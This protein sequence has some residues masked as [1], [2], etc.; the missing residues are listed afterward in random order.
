MNLSTRRRSFETIDFGDVILCGV[1]FL[2]LSPTIIIIVVLSTKRTIKVESKATSL[3]GLA[4]RNVFFSL[5]E[6]PRPIV[7]ISISWTS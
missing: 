2:G 6:E 3:K 1:P 4:D 5:S 7:H